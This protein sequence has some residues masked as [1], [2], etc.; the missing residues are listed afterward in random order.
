[1]AAIRA[2]ILRKG[3]IGVAFDCYVSDAGPRQ[4]HSLHSELSARPSWSEDTD[5]AI[6]L[7][8]DTDTAPRV[9]LD[10]GRIGEAAFFVPWTKMTGDEAAIS[11]VL[12]H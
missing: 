2:A 12:G 3:M 11:L 8:N 6:A 7:V 1:M 9:N 4:R 10:L 5:P